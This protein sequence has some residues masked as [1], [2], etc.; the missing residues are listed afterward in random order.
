[1]VISH[2]YRYLFIEL[3]QT[4]SSTVAQELCELYDGKR[5]L[6]KHATYRD[7]LR[8]ATH[9]EKGYFVFSGIRNPMDKTVSLYYKYR[10]NHSS[11]RKQ[12]LGHDAQPRHRDNNVFISWLMRKQ[13]EFIR[14]RDATF[15][16]FF[17]QFYRLPYD[18]WSCLDHDRLDFVIHFEQLAEDFE[19][20][21][22]EL[23]IEPKRRLP[24]RNKTSERDS[25]FWAYYPPDLRARA[26]WIFAPY[27]R[28]WGY[29]FP[30]DWS[31]YVP[32]TSDIAF[33]ITNVF[34]RFYWKHVR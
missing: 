19:K 17:K 16:D 6:K 12:K 21:L 30:E 1:L 20:A 27:F 9:D 25:D 10:T 4:G 7:F 31:P 29:T 24:L 2:K 15:A 13:Y 8:T 3:P 34:R 33:R 18:D 14:N 22:F 26:K 32:A 23:G 5:I 11:K 28:R